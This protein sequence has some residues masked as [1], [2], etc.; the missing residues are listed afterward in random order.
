MFFAS[1]GGDKGQCGVVFLR[2]GFSDGGDGGEDGD[3]YKRRRHVVFV[4]AEEVLGRHEK[5]EPRAG[6]ASLRRLLEKRF[7]G[8]MVKTAEK[9]NELGMRAPCMEETS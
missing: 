2:R 3:R 5:A 7:P 1:F 6:L 4:V 8:E 9:N